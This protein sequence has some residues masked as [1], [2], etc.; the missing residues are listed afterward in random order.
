MT[1]V[2]VSVVAVVA[3]VVSYVHMHE[4]AEAA[5]EGWRAHLIPLSVDGMLVA[6]SMVMLVRRRTGQGAGVLPWVGLVLGLMASLAANIAAARPEPLSWVVSGWPAVALAVSFEL[7]ILVARDT[8][9]PAAGLSAG[10]ESS[11]EEINEASWGD[12]PGADEPVDEPVPDWWG[13]QSPA[14]ETRDEEAATPAPE[15]LSELLARGVGRR[16]LAKELGVSEHT[17]REILSA[18][19]TNREIA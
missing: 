7:L 1:V 2:A 11:A 13:P 18:H 3:A 12:W 15:R 19:K 14:V 5:G 6:A 8:N 17:A 16:R 9:T 4:L 10:P